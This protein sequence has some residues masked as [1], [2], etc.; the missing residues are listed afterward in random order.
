MNQFSPFFHTYALLPCIE[1]HP[2]Y[3]LYEKNIH[4]HLDIMK[5]SVDK[6]VFPFGVEDHEK[7]WIHA[8]CMLEGMAVAGVD[9]DMRKIST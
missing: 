6:H 8:A 1:K 4:F 9:T 7:K 2:E 5:I 3:C